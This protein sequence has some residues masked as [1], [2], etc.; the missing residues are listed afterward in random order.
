MVLVTTS[1]KRLIQYAILITHL[2]LLNLLFESNA[3][4][5]TRSQVYG[6]ALDRQTQTAFVQGDVSYTT[7]ESQAAASKETSEST[8]WTVGTYAGEARKLGISFRGTYN[9]IPFALNKSQMTSNWHDVRIQAR[10]GWLYP[11]VQAGLT[12]IEVS[13]EEAEEIDLLATQVGVGLG[14]HIPLWHKVVFFSDASIMTTSSAWDK[15]G[16]EVSLSPRQDVDVGASIDII[17]KYLDFL[18]GYRSRTYN[19][20]VEDRELKESHLGAYTGVRL[21][22]YF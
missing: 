20:K 8:T 19:I 21:G 15:N 2:I 13:G 10:F 3:Y 16:R 18:V 22:I 14:L 5:Q 17:E 6:T 11:S 1:G 9:D 12:Q 7:F 4:A